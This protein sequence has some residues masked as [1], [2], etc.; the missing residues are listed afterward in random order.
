MENNV[1][2][3]S[4]LIQPHGAIKQSTSCGAPGRRAQNRIKPPVPEPSISHEKHQ[5]SLTVV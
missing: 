1:S 2:V 4:S 5:D 3:K